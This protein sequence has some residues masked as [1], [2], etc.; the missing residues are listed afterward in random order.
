MQGEI[1]MGS[2]GKTRI[3]SRSLGLT[4]ADGFDHG[5]LVEVMLN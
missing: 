2:D 1:E 4:T 3:E 5:A